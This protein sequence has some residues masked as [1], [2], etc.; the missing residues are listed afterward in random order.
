MVSWGGDDCYEFS[1]EPEIKKIDET[2][3]KVRHL[4]IIYCFKTI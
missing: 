2:K 4:L 3:K 1:F